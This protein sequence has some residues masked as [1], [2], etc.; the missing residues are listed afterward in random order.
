VLFSYLTTIELEL[1]DKNGSVQIGTQL[2]GS[3][4]YTSTGF[5]LTAGDTYSVLFINT[6]QS[7]CSATDCRSNVLD[8]GHEIGLGPNNLADPVRFT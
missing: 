1:I 6:A 5:T 2:T 4:P 8:V 7:G 3:N